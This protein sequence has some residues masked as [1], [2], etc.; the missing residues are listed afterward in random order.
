[1]QPN[2][3]IGAG[4]KLGL[5]IT[6]IGEAITANPKPDMLCRADPATTASKA[7]MNKDG[8]MSIAVC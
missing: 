6:K 4:K 1:M 3:N 2:A 8:S 5:M 7:T